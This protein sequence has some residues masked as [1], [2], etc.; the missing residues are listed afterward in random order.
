MKPDTDHYTNWIEPE[1]I[2]E[3]PID[4]PPAYIAADIKPIVTRQLE[5]ILD[6]ETAKQECPICGKVL[7]YDTLVVS[8]GPDFVI[9]KHCQP[10]I[11]EWFGGQP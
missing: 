9:H 7:G 8:Y 6:Y 1:P 5:P 3:T 10:E 11:D 4:F 2:D